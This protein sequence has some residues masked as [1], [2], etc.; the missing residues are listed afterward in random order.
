MDVFRF[1]DFAVDSVL[2]KSLFCSWVH[3]VNH[4]YGGFCK[5]FHEIH[6]NC[7]VVYVF[8]SVSGD[9]GKCLEMNGF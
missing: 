8:C 2:S 6:K 3:W 1:S 4:W 9:Q 7:Q 5:S